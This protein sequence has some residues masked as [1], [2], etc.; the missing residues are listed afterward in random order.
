M[1]GKNGFSVLMSVY[2]NDDAACLQEALASIF[3]QTYLPAEVVLVAD[4]PLSVEADA[5]LE[6]YKIKCK[7][8]RLPQNRGL[9][10]ALQAGLKECSH[11][12]VARM[13][14]DDICLPTRFELQLAAFAKDKAL[15]VCG[16][17]IEEIDFK[18]KKPIALRRLPLGD[19]EIKQFI[20]FRCPFNHMTVMFKKEDIL[21]CGGYEPKFLMEDYSLW[22]N[23]A[24][25]GLKMQNLP[26]VLV[27]A[28]MDGK[29]YQRRGGYKYFKSN[30]AL[31]EQ[32]LSY[33]MISLPTYIFNL[34]VR[35]SVQVIMPDALRGLF[36]KV[37]LRS[38]KNAK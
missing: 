34:F 13:D 37:A 10:A 6:L 17:A 26:Q 27:R 33:G 19:A 4:G 9:G 2:K 1:L 23:C 38:G 8:I 35:F 11:P 21:S 14:S 20:K 15:S 16:G 31:Q 3:A 32:M 5:V 18:T 24:A 30:K 28:R 22:V 7:I 12:L 36:Y 25:K 29:S